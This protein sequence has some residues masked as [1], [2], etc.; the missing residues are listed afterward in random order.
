MENET[1][2]QAIE[3]TTTTQTTDSTD[4]EF[5]AIIAGSERPEF[6]PGRTNGGRQASFDAVAAWNAVGR[7]D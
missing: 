4:S 2:A 7:I 6:A 5:L 3:T 1:M